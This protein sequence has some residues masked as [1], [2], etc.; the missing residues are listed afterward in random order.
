MLTGKQTAHTIPKEGHLPA[1]FYSVVSFTTC[2]NKVSFL[3]FSGKQVRLDTITQLSGYYNGVS[4]A[5]TMSW[6]RYLP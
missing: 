5:Q 3:T 1:H 2:E 6:Q 4:R